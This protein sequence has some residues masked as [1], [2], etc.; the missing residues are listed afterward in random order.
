[1]VVSKLDKSISYPEIKS[2][3]A[4]DK[5][6]TVELYSI[7]VKDKDIVVAIGNPNHTYSDKN[8]VYHPIYMIKKSGKAVQIGV[9]EMLTTEVISLTDE[10][11]VIEVEKLSDPL[12]YVFANKNFIET[13]RM[14]PPDEELEIAKKE[15]EDDMESNPDKIN[16]KNDSEDDTEKDSSHKPEQGDSLS[17]PSYRADIFS[18]DTNTNIPPMLSEETLEDAKRE[19]LMYKDGDMK[20]AS[21]I[22]KAMKNMNYNLIETDNTGD[23][24]FDA[25]RVAFAQIGQITTVAQLRK[26]L[27][28][29]VNEELFNN[30]S[31]QY[32]KAAQTVLVEQ[33]NAKALE[34]EYNNYKELV[35]S[36]ISSTEQNEHIKNAKIVAQQHNNAISSKKNAHEIYS[37]F[38]FMKKVKS[39]EEL[40]KVVQTPEF[41]ADSWAISTLERLLNIKFIIMSSEYAKNDPN[42]ILQCGMNIDSHL[43][44]KGTFEPEF[45]IILEYTGQHYRVIT[46]KNKAI[47]KYIELPYDLK[48]MVVTK[49]MERKSGPFILIPEF[50]I[51]A[52]A[53]DANSLKG[54][55]QIVNIDILTSVDPGVVFQFYEKSMDKPPGKGSGEKIEP[56]ERRLEFSQLAPKGE[57]PNWRRKLD[58]TWYHQETPLEIDDHKWNSVEHYVQ[59][60]KFKNTAPDFYNEFTAESESEISKNVDI[61]IAAGSKNGKKGKTVIRDPKY[62]IDPEFYGKN[63]K[64]AIKKAMTVKFTEIPHFRGL[65]KA[66]K[67]ATLNKYIPKY[68]PEVDVNLITIRNTLT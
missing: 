40:V 19:T 2:I 1:M 15:S 59:A 29:E 24:F 20:S 37:E 7:E 49:C 21:W 30:Y 22:Q 13:H 33:K 44:S 60:N 55:E 61:A 42:N 11:G 57:Y 54:S 3:M 26:K 48:E 66:T 6:L 62:R 32:N 65:L 56:A 18:L 10:N 4:D 12:I 41:W 28:R 9:Y 35:S 53:L 46:Y 36:T 5:E 50:R 43:E 16:E 52:E 64:E 31:E 14:I 25:I 23:C 47:F 38:K 8:V 68:S 63:E 45:Y 17:I 67:N 51:L 39:V 34:T 27:S 58:N